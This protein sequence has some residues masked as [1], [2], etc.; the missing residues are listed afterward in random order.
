MKW[1]R[2]A[3]GRYIGSHKFHGI[4]MKNFLLITLTTVV[5]L[6]VISFAV[7][8]YISRTME[9]E[10]RSQDINTLTRIKNTGDMMALEGDLFS[11]KIASD[12]D[13]T[14]LLSY[15]QIVPADLYE[16]F[17]NLYD[18]MGFITTTDDFINSVY[19]YFDNSRFVFSTEGGSQSIDFFQ[20]KGWLSDYERKRETGTY[21]MVPRS[22]TDIFNVSDSHTFISSFRT[23]SNYGQSGVVI[24]NLDTQRMKTVLDNAYNSSSPH[25]LMIVDKTGQILYAT[26]AAQIGRQIGDIPGVRHIAYDHSHTDFTRSAAGV[27]Q[28]ASVLRSGYNDWSY[29]SISPVS[30]YTRQLDNFKI[31]MIVAVAVCLLLAILIAFFISVKIYQPVKNMVALFQTRSDW[32]DALNSRSGKGYDEFRYLTTGILRSFD[33]TREMEKVLAERLS[34]LRKSQSIALQAQINPHFLY[35]TL[36][37]I[38]WK[39]MGLTGGENE[40]SHMIELLSRLLRLSLETG[41]SMVTIG[42][43]V[44][45]AKYYLEIQKMRYKDKF[46]IRWDIA[47][48]TVGCKIVKLTL[49]PLVENAIYHG[50]KPKEGH[51]TIHIVSRQEPGGIGI[52]VEDDG[53]GMPPD[54]AAALNADMKSQYIRENEHIGLHNVNQRIKLMFGE[55]YGITV[56]SAPGRGTCVDLHIPRLPA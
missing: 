7:Y 18:I 5:P 2:I 35:N 16:K 3:F 47:A 17:N 10:I 34:L 42:E 33:R 4:L 40:V 11:A 20:D 51:G 15:P 32:E 28:I 37:T 30:A 14:I 49:Q 12:T 29:I 54:T 56:T 1:E 43:E 44:D 39:A 25:S 36:E 8:H 50:I 55:K 48:D 21:W 22:V 45:H 53:V 52:R 41:T 13:V 27:S 19:I 46:D 31:F 23:M 24:V 26:D 6:I 9:D 38:N